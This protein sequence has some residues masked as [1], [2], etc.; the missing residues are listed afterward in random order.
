MN[1]FK[2]KS[3]LSLKLKITF[4]NPSLLKQALTHRSYLNEHKGENLT[5]NERLEFLGD[6]ILEFLTSKFLFRSLPSRPEGELTNIRS[7]IV[8]TSSLAK[9]AQKLNLGKH[10]LL[11]R[12]EKESGGQKNKTLLA[13]TFEALIGAIYLDQGLKATEKFVYQNLLLNAKENIDKISVK[14]YKS[15]LQE[16]TQAEIKQS[17]RYRILKEV[18]PEHNKTFTVGVYYNGQIQGKGIGKSKQEAEQKAAYSALEET[19]LT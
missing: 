2:K 14:D 16:K 17:P 3:N 7:N 18:G 11:S 9:V 12:G 10:L 1:K 5:S 8:C 15:L 13:N 19:G 6:A 4:K